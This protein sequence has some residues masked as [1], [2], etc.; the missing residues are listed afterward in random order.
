M[1][2]GIEQW[3]AGIFCKRTIFR[4][5]V[6][7]QIPLREIFACLFYTLARLYFTIWISIIIVPFSILFASSMLFVPDAVLV[8]VPSC[9]VKDLQCP[10]KRYVKLISI[11]DNS[12]PTMCKR[13]KVDGN[14]E[15][16]IRHLLL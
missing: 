16:A 2:V 15:K 4:V 3:R 13:F 8:G 14:H 7:Y 1:P 12:L 5:K 11:F 6:L 9:R 10:I